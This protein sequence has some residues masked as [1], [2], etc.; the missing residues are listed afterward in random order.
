[1]S[2]LE[3]AQAR[4]MLDNYTHK[5]KTSRSAANEWLESELRRCVKLYGAGADS[6]IRK[7]MRYIKDEER[8][9]V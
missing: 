9:G 2:L 8:C 5:A 6:R 7:A 1:M 4:E 3:L